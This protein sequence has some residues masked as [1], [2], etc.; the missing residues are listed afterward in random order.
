MAYNKSA[1]I[2]TIKIIVIGFVLNKSICNRMM[3]RKFGR[4]KN[5]VRG[6]WTKLHME[7]LY[8]LV[9]TRYFEGQGSSEPVAPQIILTVIKVRTI[10]WRVC[11]MHREGEICS[12]NLV[13]KS[14]ENKLLQKTGEGGRIILK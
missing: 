7:K 9:F 13:R 5:V 10:K 12:Q 8:K 2:F 4:E 11:N 3:R 1:L 14:E 6:V